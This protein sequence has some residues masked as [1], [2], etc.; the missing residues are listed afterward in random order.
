MFQLFH[1]NTIVYGRPVVNDHPILP[2]I[3]ACAIDHLCSRF[4]LSHDENPNAISHE[5]IPLQN[6]VLLYALVVLEQVVTPLCDA[7]S[8]GVV[9]ETHST[10]YNNELCCKTASVLIQVLVLS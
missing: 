4:F 8:L 10:S 7:A 1:Q 5:H 2:V 6:Y 3:T 9:C